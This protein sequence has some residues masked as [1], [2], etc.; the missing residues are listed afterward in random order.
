[1]QAMVKSDCNDC[2]FRKTKFYVKRNYSGGG[3]MFALS[4][5]KTNS[6]QKAIRLLKMN[7]KS[8]IL[9]RQRLS[10]F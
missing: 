8:H 6:R 9:Q 1:M 3:L 10:V 4:I 2:N 7:Q 5:V